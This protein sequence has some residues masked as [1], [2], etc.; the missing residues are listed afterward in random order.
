MDTLTTYI[1]MCDT[2]EIQDSKHSKED[3]KTWLTKKD[4]LIDLLGNYWSSG[5]YQVWLPMQDQIQEMLGDFRYCLSIVTAKGY[6]ENEFPS[7][8]PDW[9]IEDKY[10]SMEQYWLMEYMDKKHNKVWDE[11]KW[12]KSG[13]FKGGIE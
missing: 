12:V 3:N 11:D 5:H 2:Q 10:E 6:L 4:V 8:L 13:K 1:K 7:D 9:Y